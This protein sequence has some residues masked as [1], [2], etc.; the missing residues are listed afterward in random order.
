MI[1]V[2]HLR[3]KGGNRDFCSHFSVISETTSKFPIVILR[4][5]FGKM[6]VDGVTEPRRESEIRYESDLKVILKSLGCKQGLL[7]S[8]LIEFPDSN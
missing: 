6:G 7:Q 5:V 3:N 8:F 1:F 2:S 4:L